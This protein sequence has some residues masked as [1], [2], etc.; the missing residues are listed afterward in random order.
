MGLL[1]DIKSCCNWYRHNADAKDFTIYIIFVIIF[2]IV[3]FSSKPGV[4]QYNLQQLAIGNYATCDNE[5]YNDFCEVTSEGGIF[6]FLR[7]H[8]GSMAFP[9]AIYNGEKLDPIRRLFINGQGRFMGAY[10]IRAVR[11]V[12]TECNIPKHLTDVDGNV[13]KCSTA[14]SFGTRDKQPFGPRVVLDSLTD[15]LEGY[16]NFTLPF[17]YQT[18]AELNTTLGYVEQGYFASYFQDGYAL[19]VVPNIASD[20]LAQKLSDCKMLMERSIEQCRVRFD[21]PLDTISAPPP[22][23]PPS[24]P[25]L[26][27]LQGAPDA[28]GMVLT[29]ST[30]G[31][32]DFSSTISAVITLDANTQ[33]STLSFKLHNPGGIDLVW[34][35]ASDSQSAITSTEWITN[36]APFAY[37]GSLG[38]IGSGFESVPDFQK[39]GSTFNLVVGVG[40]DFAN[41]QQLSS[42]YVTPASPTATILLKFESPSAPALGQVTLNVTVQYKIAANTTA[43]ASSMQAVG[44]SGVNSSTTNNNS[45]A[46]TNSSTSGR[47]LLGFGST[48][49][50]GMVASAHKLRRLKQTVVCQEPV[51]VPTGLAPHLH[52]CTLD[53]TLDVDNTCKFP[54]VGFQQML[55]L[56][57]PARCGECA[58]KPWDDDFCSSQCTA[59]QIFEEQLNVLED[60]N[61]LEPPYTRAVLVDV[62]VLHQNFNLF[63]TIR[64]F[65]ELPNI[66]G[67]W[68]KFTIRTFRLYRYI[69]AADMAVAALEIIFCVMIGY[70]LVA[71]ILEIKKQKWAYFKDLWNYVDWTNLI[72]FII[73]IA[74]RLGSLVYIESFEFDSVTTEYIDF[75]PIGF[76]AIQEL[77][78]S[79]INFFLMYFKIFKYLQ[80]VPR[81]NSLLV[82]VSTG[83]VDLVLFMIIFLLV[84]WGFAAAF[85]V[86]FGADL[87][88]YS[89]PGNSFSTLLRILLGDFDY[90]A[91]VEQNAIMAPALFISFNIIAFFI[92]L[93]MFLAIICDSYAE[94]KG[95]QSDEDLQY[96]IELSDKIMSTIREK[97]R[98]LTTRKKQVHE[99][100]Q[101]LQ[102]ADDN[103]DGMIDEEELAEVLKNNPKAAEILKTSGAKEL[104]AKYDVSGDGVLDKAEMTEILKQLATQEAELQHKIE[105]EHK[106]EAKAVEELKTKEHETQLRFTSTAMN[107][108][109]SKLEDRLDKVEGQI[110]DMSRNVAKK[111]SLMVDLMLSLSDSVQHGS[112]HTAGSTTQ[113]SAVVVPR[114]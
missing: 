94:V 103:I 38:P 27:N 42:P 11:S 35:L 78:V 96:Y 57:S 109:T 102:S 48:S 17:T 36:K 100:T 93:N 6:G 74:L 104:L 19:D 64:L 76:A 71:E 49:S 26:P 24:P 59:K 44:A 22:S 10:R 31:V 60:A 50:R 69:T 5:N 68:P 34:E 47:R 63:Q 88:E 56:M 111:L 98:D 70:Y 87:F 29:A 2:S 105:E 8:F 14:Y 41:K 75:L 1:A 85:Y 110:K 40:S 67:A 72:I 23:P 113:T 53:K 107:F 30:V 73:V 82:T 16:G 92:L 51:V 97:I 84:M 3:T 86:S 114:P 28:P 81:M 101:S 15:Y 54:Y 108:D 62:A 18:A 21:V 89:T 45:P 20:T 77:N 58:C 39:P 99:L 4:V 65:W 83:F 79:A 37:S 25:P 112:T 106:E 55:E 7:E 91:L 90:P 95:N 13:T 66:G 33:S 80:H 9:D 32:N 46:V 43:G 12:E 61:W 52:K